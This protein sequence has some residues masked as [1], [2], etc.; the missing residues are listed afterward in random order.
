MKAAVEPERGDIEALV[1]PDRVE[2]ERL[3]DRNGAA[4]SDARV[5]AGPHHLGNPRPP[6]LTSY[7]LRSRG[8]DNSAVSDK[9]ALSR[10][11]A[12]IR[13]CRPF[14]TLYIGLRSL[15]SSWRFRSRCVIHARLAMELRS[16]NAA[17]ASS[18]SRSARSRRTPASRW[19]R[20][21]R[22]LRDAYGVSAE[23]PSE[24][25]GLG[26]EAWLSPA[27]SRPAPCEGDPIRL[28]FCSPTSATRSS[29]TF[30]DGLN[31][32]LIRTQY[33]A[34]FGRG[35]ARQHRSSRRWWTRCSIA[36]ST[37]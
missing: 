29:P 8:A 17:E 2:L 26:R 9:R 31:T 23:L 21:R 33:Q 19:P 7:V 30:I 16:T 32:A 11:S 3:V 13:L 12:T 1:A 10:D 37:A 5:R 14:Y 22:C 36:R 6:R 4:L 34:L 18:A 27:C 35:T 28:V 20:C 24:S 15:S 25:P